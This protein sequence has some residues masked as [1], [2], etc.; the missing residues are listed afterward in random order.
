[1][2]DRDLGRQSHPAAPVPHGVAFGPLNEEITFSGVII[3]GGNGKRVQMAALNVFLD[4][5]AIEMGMEVVP[6]RS[7]I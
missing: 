1:M 5:V 7:R 3:G 4:S 2:L 6:Q